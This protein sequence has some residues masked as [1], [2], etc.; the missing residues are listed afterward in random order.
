MNILPYENIT[1]KTHLSKEE[2]LNRLNQETEPKQWIRM[3][4]IF[5]SGNHKAYEGVV[6]QNSFKISR[7]IGYRNSFLPR[8]EG[9]IEEKVEGNSKITLIHIKMRLHTFVLVFLCVW[10]SFMFLATTFLIPIF[11]QEISNPSISN[12]AS[13]I[14]FLMIPFISLITILA[15]H[16]EGNKSKIFFENLFE[17]ERQEK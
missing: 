16:Y 13:I 12:L 11:K 1:Y 10:L 5:S 8:I 14:P 4:G 15:F 3:T 7:I 6:N 17:A 9:E 2:I